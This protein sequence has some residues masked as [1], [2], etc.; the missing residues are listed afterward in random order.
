MSITP[1]ECACEVLEVV[2]LIM[3]AIR[4][5][6]RSCRTPD[7]SVPQFRALTF[8]HGRK[9]ASLSD[10][11]EHV[12]LTLPSMSKMIDGLVARRL[13]KRQAHPQDR[14]RVKLALTARGQTA[15]E[16]AYGATRARLAERLAALPASQRITVARAMGILRPAFTTGREADVETLRRILA[17]PRNTSAAV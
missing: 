16:V 15:L 7:L 2:P 3:R 13:V 10:V 11:A 1:D 6:M 4:A 9:G 12:G 14:R 17:D 5:Q 8:L